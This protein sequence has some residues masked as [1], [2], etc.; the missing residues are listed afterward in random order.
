MLGYEESDIGV[1]PDEW[2]DRV[3]PDD[4]AACQERADGPPRA[5]EATTTRASTGCC[6][7][8]ARFGGCCA[9]ARP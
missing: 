1:S 8:A 7:E 9:A 3:H 5:T 6:I 4:I 2:F